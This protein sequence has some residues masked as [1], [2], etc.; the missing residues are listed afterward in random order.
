VHPCYLAYREQVLRESGAIGDGSPS[1]SPLP[2]SLQPVRRGPVALPMFR[3]LDLR[4]D[5]VVAE[6]PVL[7]RAN[8]LTAARAEN[9]L[10]TRAAA[11]GAGG[12]RMSRS[13]A[14]DRQ[15]SDSVESGGASPG[16]RLRHE[17]EAQLGCEG[18]DRLRVP[19]PR[20]VVSTSAPKAETV[21]TGGL[22]PPRNRASKAEG[23]GAPGGR[24]ISRWPFPFPRRV[25]RARPALE[26]RQERAPA[27]PSSPRLLGGGVGTPPGGRDPA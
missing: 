13:F 18:P 14:R 24:R 22:V 1:P 17:H 25:R 7:V 19:L 5:V 26:L 9:L 12:A 16:K 8:D 10:A 27:N 20:C 21:Q 3:S 6:I 4:V 15:A 23:K 2:R 11:R